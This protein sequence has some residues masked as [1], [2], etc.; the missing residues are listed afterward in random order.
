MGAT[1]GRTNLG[2]GKCEEGW[3]TR[4]KGGSVGK[5]H[6]PFAERVVMW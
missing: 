4:Y 2:K 3:E 5:V 6:Q 1:R